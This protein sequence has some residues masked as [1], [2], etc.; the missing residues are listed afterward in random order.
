MVWQEF[1]LACNCY[2][3]TPAYLGELEQEAKSLINRLRGHPSLVL[4]CGGNELFNNWSGMTDQSPALRMLASLCWQLD[5]ARPFLP[6][7]PVDGVGH[8]PY[9]FRDHVGGGE[10][11]S[12]F[13]T[14][15][16][17]A[18]N[19]FGCSAP[20]FADIAHAVLPEAERW[21]PRPG[22]SWDSHTG[23][24]PGDGFG[25]HQILSHL[26][27]YLG[28]PTS[29]E[30]FEMKGQLLQREGIRGLYEEAR[31]QKPHAAMALAWCLNEPW[32]TLVN[33]SLVAW[34]DRP[35]C[36]YDGA[37]L[38]CRPALASA[39]I[40]K[41]AW[42]AGERF[43]PQFWILNDAPQPVAAGRMTAIL[44]FN[45]TRTAFGTW[46][47]PEV[48]ANQNLAGPTFA[49]ELPAAPQ[50][51]FELELTVEGRPGLGSTY[52]L[53]FAPPDPAML[54]VRGPSER[55]VRPT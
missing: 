1:P 51:L 37:K 25:G 5:P 29:L 52:T 36:G 12:V 31:R 55:P 6:T 38:A 46:D 20:T 27:R 8:G 7:S 28:K 33:C 43:D 23:V 54:D 22:T 53:C 18:Y 24:E 44:V 26:E 16:C 9:T 47:F 41:F 50:G 11:W 48:A 15:A 14:S 19:E 40:R 21:P 30:D 45:G 2:A 13:Q 4:W 39:R 10:I 17:T 49:L 3:E 42:A 34:P 35:K 32:P